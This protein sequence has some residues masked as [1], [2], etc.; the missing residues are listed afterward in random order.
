MDTAKTI[1]SLREQTGM[2]RREFSEYT[3]I[4]VRNV[5]R[6]GGGQT[7]SARIYSQIIGVSVKYDEL[8]KGREHGDGEDEHR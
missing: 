7:D 6:L 2:N 3:G 5:R 4:P 1:R 8:V